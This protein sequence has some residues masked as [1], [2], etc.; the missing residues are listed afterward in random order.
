[1][2]IL[3]ELT[4]QQESLIPPIRDKWLGIGLATGQGDMTQARLAIAAA[5]R[6]VGLQPPASYIILPSPLHGSIAAAIL[7]HGG[8]QVGAQVWNQVWNQVR[9]QVWNQVRNQVRNQGRTQVRDE[10]LNQV[11]NQVRD[12]VRT[13]VWAQ[14][15]NQV[16]D[17]VRNQVRDQVRT[18]VRTQVR[19]QVLDQVWNQVRDQVW[20]QVRDQVRTQVWNQVRTQVR[21]QVLNQV[22]DQVE[23]QVASCGYGQHD[24][25]WLAF[26][27]FFSQCGH[28]G[29]AKMLSRLDPFMSLAQHAGWWWPMAEVCIITERPTSLHRDE[30]GRLHSASGPAID[31]AGAWGI[32]AW[33]G[34][35][36]PREVI[37]HPEGISIRDALEEQNTEMRR[38]MLTRIGPA[39]L[40]AELPMRVLDSD[41]DGRGQQRH[42]FTLKGITDRRFISYTCP[43]TGW[44]YPAQPVPPEVRTCAEAVAWRFRA[45]DVV[46]GR[47]TRR[48]DY[49]PTQEG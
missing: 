42:L 8:A 41:T 6:Q 35:R 18:Q 12:Q 13:Q 38:V 46:D 9:D 34:V 4:L 29:L 31:Y 2:T 17:Q 32:W 36:V 25:N 15:R 26:Y 33:H 30:Q 39:R 43:S 5:Y 48:F 23:T 40:Q 22:R 1:M 44:L 14:V 47:L 49:A 10:V 45:L 27:D 37:E 16:R 19:D 20:N 28:P 3:R 7:S 11:W 24:A 21:D